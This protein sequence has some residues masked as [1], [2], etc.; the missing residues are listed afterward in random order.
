MQQQQQRSVG[1]GL[2]SSMMMTKVLVVE[3]SVAAAVLAAIACI[4]WALG[5]VTC[6]LLVPL[7]MASGSRTSRASLLRQ[8]VKRFLVLVCCC[9]VSVL[10]LL[11]VLTP[12]VGAANALQPEW[13]WWLVRGSNWGT[14]MVLC[15]LYLP[16][17]LVVTVATGC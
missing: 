12:G 16:C 5:Y 14:F 17:W 9:P 4:N 10:L 2:C 13:L 8:S 7:A 11:S 1:G 15:A 6:L 3:L